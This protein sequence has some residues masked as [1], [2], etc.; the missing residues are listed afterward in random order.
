M[1]LP[2]PFF[3]RSLSF[4]PKRTRRWRRRVLLER[5]EA[6][7]LLASDWRDPVDALER[8]QDGP[9]APLDLQ[10]MA[11]QA[12]VS[13]DLPASVAITNRWNVDT[14]GRPD[15]PRTPSRP[16]GRLG[17][18][19]TADHAQ[20]ELVH[21]QR[22]SF[23]PRP[24]PPVGYPD[25]APVLHAIEDREVMPVG[26]I[27]TRFDAPVDSIRDAVRGVDGG[28]WPDGKT[29]ASTG[30]FSIRSTAASLGAYANEF[31]TSG[32]LFEAVP[33]GEDFRSSG[34]DDAQGQEPMSTAGAEPGLERSIFPGERFD[35]G[36]NS[37][38]VTLGDMNGDGRLDVLTTNAGG[39]NISL[40]LGNG[41]GRFQTLRMFAVGDGP[42]SMAIGDLNGDDSLDVITA[43]VHSMN[44]SVLLGNG[45]GTFQDQQTFAV[46]SDP[47]SV[48][49]GDV[50]GDGWLDVVTANTGSWGVSLLIGKGDG[51]FEEQL[52][53]SVGGS[54]TSVT[55]GDV[56][57]DTRLDLLTTNGRSD[58]VSVLLGNGDGTFI[59]QGAYAVRENPRS[60]SLGD[61]NGDGAL[62]LV[63]MNAGN[64]GSATVSLLFGQG[65]GTFQEQQTIAACCSRNS[66]S[67][68]DLNG[69][70]RLD[71]ITAGWGEHFVLIGNGDGTFQTETQF[72]STELRVVTHIA[73]GDIDG[74][75]RPDL[76]SLWGGDGYNPESSFFVFIGNGDG[77]F[78]TPFVQSYP[79][80]L[81]QGSSFGDVNEDGI[82]DLLRYSGSDVL[83]LLGNG[84]GAFEEQG[85][86]TVG[87]W[88]SSMMLGDLN[89]D[90]NLDVLI[91]GVTDS[92]N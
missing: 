47:T 86:F 42:V 4:Q 3:G 55:L 45:D 35:V 33:E 51:T 1:L 89:E 91:T 66:L 12:L 8:N 26:N 79:S 25:S 46:G 21:S 64:A 36:N 75:Q 32:G 24:L 30:L 19:E 63:T 41:H 27:A 13:P 67:L 7:T 17:R 81:A 52:Y 62:D 20:V 50:N 29:D 85:R 49:V 60:I 40:L 65:D 9:V 78:V 37:T 14:N 23:N 53:I 90:G 10:V 48:V 18:F 56:N 5:L 2:E 88:A 82:L 92:W 54:P 70:G 15:L 72:P 58:S 61:I 39:N 44:I 43:N 28:T 71:M 73:L 34:E 84:E 80:G 74:D 31:V 77:S 11:N 87:A 6:R 83:V 22:L 38:F 68:A 16:A 69:D 59:Y 76:I 57:D